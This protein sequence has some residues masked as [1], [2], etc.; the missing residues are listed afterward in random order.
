MRGGLRRSGLRAALLFASLCG[1]ALPVDA[2]TCAKADFEAVV[3]EAAGALRTLNQKN[4]PVFQ[5][6]L[7]QLKDKRGWTNDQFLT[8]AE[9]LVRDETIVGFDQ[10]SEDLLAR[11]TQG[12]QSGTARAP[13]CAFLAELRAQMAMLVET[14]KA[15]WSY[16]FERIEKE[17]A[18]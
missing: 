13:D 3:D 17:L 8:Q 15:K 10:K 14:Q 18:K 2:Q 11:I 5:A 4:T 9:P 16:M 12:G 7:R 6:K 1:P